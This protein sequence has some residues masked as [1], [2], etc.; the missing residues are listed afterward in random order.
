MLPKEEMTFTRTYIYIHTLTTKSGTCVRFGHCRVLHL[1]RLQSFFS[2][3]KLARD[4]GLFVLYFIG[5]DEKFNNTD[6]R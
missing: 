2:Q 5:N 6:S 1:C 3:T 4:F